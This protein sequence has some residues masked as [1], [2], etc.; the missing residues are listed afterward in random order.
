MAEKQKLSASVVVLMVMVAYCHFVVVVVVF[1]NGAIIGRVSG[2]V[3]KNL[4]I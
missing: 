4:I 3:C 1:L 2:W